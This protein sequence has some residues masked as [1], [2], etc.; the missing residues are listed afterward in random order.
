MMKIIMAIALS[1]VF[2]MDVYADDKCTEKQI[3][4]AQSL[5]KDTS[6]NLRYASEYKDRDG[7]FQEGFMELRAEKLPD[8][9]SMVIYTEGGYKEL[10]NNTDYAELNGG[11]HKV[12][13]Y[14]SDCN[15]P[16]KSFEMRV[17]L[18]KQY[19]GLS[20]D[21]KEDAWF[22]G[23][24]ENLLSNQKEKKESRI[25]TIL[26]VILVLLIIV[27]I[28]AILLILKRRKDSEQDFK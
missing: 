13:Y 26:I 7:K 24:Y 21:C 22:D 17:P 14:R 2:A 25:S 1:F 28:V 19:C 23:T 5:L 27:V 8:G 20:V 11:I 3:T 15:T 18:Y 6:Y 4:E 12:E 9:Y 16:I 10:Q